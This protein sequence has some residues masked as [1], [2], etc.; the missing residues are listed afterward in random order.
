MYRIIIKPSALKEL[1]NIP[2]PFQARIHTAILN[3]NESPRPIGIRKLVQRDD[4]YRIR[5]GNYRVLFQIE[6][7]SRIVR[8]LE[9]KHRKDA[10][11]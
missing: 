10:Y 11:R 3:L 6:D 7:N 2:Q 8:V 1:R 4:T 9:I 5:I